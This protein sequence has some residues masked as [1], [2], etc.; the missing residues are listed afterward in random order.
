MADEAVI[1]RT[2][3]RLLAKTPKGAHDRLGGRYS[4]WRDLMEDANKSFGEKVARRI[5][6]AYEVPR[7]CLD[8]PLGDF[9]HRH[10]VK[11]AVDHVVIQAE[12][13]S[14]PP[15]TLWSDLVGADLTKPFRLPVI[16]GA[17][18]PELFPGCIARFDPFR[19]PEPAWPVLVRDRDGNHYLR[20]YQT[21]AGGRWQAVARQRGFEA[22]D[23][24]THG[25][26][27][28]AVMRGYDRP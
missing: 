2:N 5:E 18:G 1:R 22:L 3:F 20:D 24:E 14:D 25:L 16:D 26:V 28:V 21:G 6:E 9:S 19:K 13:Y 4:Y 12:N 11:G 27:I 10:L 23:S 17:L 15:L 8:D 7:G